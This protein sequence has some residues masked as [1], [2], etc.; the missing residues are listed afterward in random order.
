MKII[1]KRCLV[2]I[3]LIFI[4]I[5]TLGLVS[6]SNNINQIND[7]NCSVY[8][9]YSENI[10]TADLNSNSN[11]LNSDFAYGD[12]DSEEILD[13]PSQKLKTGSDNS[14][15]KDIQNL[16][17]NAKEND[18]IEL[19]GTYTGDSLIVVNKS[20]TLKSSSSATLDGEFLNE[21]MAINAPN[22]ILDNINFINANYTGLSVNNNY[23]TIQ[24]CNFD[25][26]INGELGCALIIHGNNVNVLN[27]NFTNNVANKSSCHHTDGAAIY[28]I[29]NDCQIDNCSFINNWG[30]NFETSSSGGA[31][32]IKGNN[33]VINNSYFFNNSATAEVGW[34]FHGEEITYLA[35]GYGGAAFLVGK[36]VK[37][38]NSLFD[39][40]L[41]HAQGGALYYKSAYDC[42]I[43]NSTFLNSF[44]VGEGG[45]IY[46]GQNIDGLMIDSCNFIN[47]TADGLDGVL[48]KYTDLGSVLYASKFAENV[49]ITNSSLLN[50]KGT[51]A[52]YFLGNNLNISNSIIENNNLSTAVIYMN[53]SMNDNFWS[54]N[55]DSADEFKNDCFIIRDNESQVPDTWFNLV[56]DGLDSLKAK[57][58]YDYN[59]SFVL[60]DASLDN[61][62][63]KI[64]LTNNL[65][66]YHIN[67]KNSAKNKINPNELVIVDNQADFTYDYIESAKDSIDVYDDY[68]NL[69]LS[70]KVLSG[71][72]YI[73]DS[74]NDTKDLQD[75]ID[76]ASSGSLISLSNKT[77]VLDTILINKDIHISGEEN[78]TVML[79]NS[80]DYIFKISNCS[81]A[82]YSDYG[83]AISNINFIL[84]N[85][86]IVAL[87]EAVNG[88]GSLSI[89]VASIKITD[90]SFTSREG[91][92]RESITILEL[93]SQRAVLAP[94]RNISISNN[95][96]EIGM[97]PFDFNVKSVIN[98]SDVRVDVGGNLASKKAS[99]IICK[100][101]VTKA[102]A[103][104]VDSRS[105][106][107]FNVSLKDSQGKPLQNKF[108]QIGF[109]GAVYNRTTNESGELRLQIN[110]AYKGVYTFAISYLGDDE[111]NGSFEVAKITVNPQSPILMA[112]NAKYKV[113]STKT[114]SASFKSMKGSPISGKT[115]KFTVDGKTYSG[116]TNSNG[117][118]SVKVSLNKKGT[119]KFTA[120]FAGDNTFA[121]VTKSAKVVIS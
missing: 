89:D 121:A 22:V 35:D 3:S 98:G 18:V 74:G 77:Y 57:G 112:N 114:L 117:I 11:E 84:D 27:S 56:C 88:S 26:C 79:S 14:D 48:V 115:I 68:N 91:V 113:S 78:T 6:A 100:D 118:A 65:P 16:I 82:N 55:F 83:I 90:N 33:I 15:F 47:N 75:A 119:Y 51:S 101:M 107:Y 73:N 54:K 111:C 105:G 49:V 34:T 103:S 5:L 25:G 2:L 21:L 72:T 4:L 67:L 61:H 8:E 46:L 41:S 42:S 28:L 59:M 53:G 81:A 97:N 71:I 17:D 76:S 94:T 23:V 93:D 60:K 44:S 12:S 36:N 29:G 31:I 20:L 110:L 63:S 85:G 109:N 19:S 62:A 13:E 24:N 69:I 1:F 70:K 102:I 87:A 32:W 7:M 39:S 99:Q 43:I 120:K 45:V 38:I 40:S 9:D 37:I 95:S 108:V 96:L 86:D 64:S 80:S 58:V 104:N 106:E 116:K 30:Y 50:N 10:I 52:V 92:V 66:N